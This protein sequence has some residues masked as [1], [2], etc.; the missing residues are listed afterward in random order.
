M[1]KLKKDYV[2]QEVLDCIAL[3]QL[4]NEEM[5]DLSSDKIW[6][7]ADSI[8]FEWNE[9][10]DPEADFSDM[11]KWNLENYITHG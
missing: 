3:K 4:N 10:G 6:V 11:V 5:P 9:L 8:L 7:I 2:V 1:S